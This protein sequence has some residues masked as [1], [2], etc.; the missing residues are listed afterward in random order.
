MA[1]SALVK[2]PLCDK[3][4]STMKHRHF[5]KHGFHCSEIGFGAWAIGDSWG[6]QANTDSIAAL[7]RAL[8]LLEKLRRHN[9]RRGFWHGDK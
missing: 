2:V 5:G 6:E 1:Q 9:W 8:D 7:H 3:N 4:N